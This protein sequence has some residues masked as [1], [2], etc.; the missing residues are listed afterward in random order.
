MI[1]SAKGKIA[2]TPFPDMSVKTSSQGTGSVKVA[3]I[4]NKITVVPLT[5]LFP[6]EDSRFFTGDVVFV[7]GN[8]YTLPWAKDVYEV[9]GRSFIL[10]PDSVVELVRVRYQYQDLSGTVTISSTISST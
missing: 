1:K 5:V 2:V 4:D 10:I 8:N 7:K 6:S 9:D 3:R